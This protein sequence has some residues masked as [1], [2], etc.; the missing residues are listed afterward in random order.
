MLKVYVTDIKAGMVINEPVK[1]KSGRLLFDKGHA[2]TIADIA[3]LM[4]NGIDHIIITEED[5][6]KGSVP[7]HIRRLEAK[8]EASSIEELKSKI[9]EIHIKRFGNTSN[10]PTMQ[11]ICNQ[12]IKY[13]IS[14]KYKI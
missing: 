13:I 12:S 7:V 10:N 9:E 1:T 5:I 11:E 8:V 14:E 6:K 2:F 3:Q 4:D